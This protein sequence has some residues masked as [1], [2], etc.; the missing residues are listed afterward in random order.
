M[1]VST[2]TT[3]GQ[4]L[5]SAYVN[6]NINSGLVYI[7]ETAFTT[8]ATPFI[9]GCF[10]STYEN[11]RIVIN[12]RGSADTAVNLRLRSATSTPETGAVYDRFG[13]EAGTSYS[14]INSANGTNALISSVSP[15]STSSMTATI[16]AFNPQISGINT[17]LMITGFNPNNGAMY[18]MTNRVE[19]STQYTGLELTPSTGTI[20][21]TIRVYGYRQA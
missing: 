1:T 21:G 16:D 3:A 17:N 5:T 20:T 2:P 15:T 19:T 7:A 18:I 11:Y 12:C 6:N 4:I 10:T 8:T 14:N 9:N 13:F